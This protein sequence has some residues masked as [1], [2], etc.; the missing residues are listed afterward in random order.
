[1][2][3]CRGS[4]SW[5]RTKAPLAY[6]EWCV[7]AIMRVKMMFRKS[8]V[9]GGKT[10]LRGQITEL[11]AQKTDFWAQE[12]ELRPEQPSFWRQQA[13]FRSCKGVET[14]FGT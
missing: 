7:A 4:M 8:R 6:G 14:M 11:Q 9:L 2:L 3:E 5:S 1:V 10:E 13:E 12:T